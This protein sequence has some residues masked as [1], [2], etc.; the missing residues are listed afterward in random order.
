PA[1]VEEIG[2][3]AFAYNQQL[4]KVS[5]ASGSRLSLL[6][7]NAF[8]GC[9][10]ISSLDFS[11]TLLVEIGKEAFNACSQL[12]SIALPATVETIG[13]EAFMYTA[14]NQIDWS[15]LSKLSVIEGS[16]FYGVGSLQ[17]VVLP[18]GIKEIKASA[19]TLCKGMSSI[20]LPYNLTTIGD[21]A[22]ANCTALLTIVCPTPAVPTVGYQA[23]Q[24]VNTANVNVEVLES[25]IS[26]YENDAIWSTFSLIGNPFTGL[27]TT[28][29]NVAQVL[30]SANCIEVVSPTMIGTITLYSY[31]GNILHNYTVNSTHAV[32]EYVAHTRCIMRIGYTNGD[33]EVVKL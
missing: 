14:I 21:W 19:F 17:S 22:F 10:L 27:H 13:D 23:F 8:N 18:L 30:R 2:V 20:S 7:N 32:V 3:A 1:S 28:H 9:S 31:N 25:I 4:N 5:I 6:G 15:H 12:N 11:E 24:G 26:Q 16:M 29:H 33:T